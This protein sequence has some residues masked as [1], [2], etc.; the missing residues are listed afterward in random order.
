MRP[1]DQQ[2]DLQVLLRPRRPRPFRRPFRHP[3][4]PFRRQQAALR[5]PCQTP[6]LRAWRACLRLH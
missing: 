5:C 1:Q 6:H 3:L 2:R 4:H